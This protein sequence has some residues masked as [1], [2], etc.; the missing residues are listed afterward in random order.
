MKYIAALTGLLLISIAPAALAGPGNDCAA[1]SEKVAVT[2]KDDFLK[3]CL[4]EAS[5]PAKIKEAKHKHKKARCE[6]NA[7]NMK[8]Q[9][10]DK[11]EYQEDCLNKNQAAEVKS[12]IAVADAN[13]TPTPP[14][15]N[16][17][18]K[19]SSPKPAEH[20]HAAKKQKEH[21]K[22]S[23]KDSKKAV[24]LSPAAAGVAETK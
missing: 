22:N 14:A 6:Q 5:A 1:R 9:G 13:A 20:N 16:D 4:A 10:K 18:Q 11:G 21:K 7:K 17:S 2:E 24:K 23:K 3:T 8:L 12:N 15:A 19:S